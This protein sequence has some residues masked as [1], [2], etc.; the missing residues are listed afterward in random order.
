MIKEPESRH[1]LDALSRK[2]HYPSKQILIYIL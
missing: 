1:D 2:A